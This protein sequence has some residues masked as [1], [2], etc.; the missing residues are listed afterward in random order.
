MCASFVGSVSLHHHLAALLLLG[1]LCRS[2]MIPFALGH[3]LIVLFSAWYSAYSG[4]LVF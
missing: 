2:A 3:F 1:I 4:I